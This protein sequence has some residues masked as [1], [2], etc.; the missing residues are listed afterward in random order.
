[1]QRKIVNPV[2]MQCVA[3]VRTGPPFLPVVI[4][5]RIARGTH[6]V[7]KAVSSFCPQVFYRGLVVYGLKRYTV[8]L[9][10]AETTPVR[11]GLP[12]SPRPEVE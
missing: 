6:P 10:L 8:T 2:A 1:M 11:A 9:R 7:R 4:T 5:T 12:A 3:N